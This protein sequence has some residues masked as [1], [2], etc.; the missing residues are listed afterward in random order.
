MVKPDFSSQTVMGTLILP[1]ARVLRTRG[2]GPI[3]ML[4]SLSIDP[5]LIARPAWRMCTAF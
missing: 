4:E 2:M 1:I 5:A 3:E